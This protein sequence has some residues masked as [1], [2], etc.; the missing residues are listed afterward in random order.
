MP[1]QARH[2]FLTGQPGV[3]KTTL[4]CAAVKEQPA[5]CGFYTAEKRAAAGEREGF[6]V[7]AL[8]SGETGTLASLGRGKA[9][10]GKYCVDVASFERV[11]LPSLEASASSPIT[12]IDE[13]GKMEL[14]SPL[15]LPR[16]E[17]I[18]TSGEATV[19][20]TLPMPRYGHTIA[21]VE[22][23][24]AHPDVAVV[25]LTKANREAA[26]LA[27]RAVVAAAAARPRPGAPLDVSALVDFLQDGQEEKLL[28]AQGAGPGAP[29]E[30]AAQQPV[31]AVAAMAPA[32]VGAVAAVA[33]AAPPLLGERPRVLLLGETASAAPAPGE[34]PYAE[35]S[36]W[37]VRGLSAA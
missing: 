4:A 12:L 17:A 5:S 8:G 22:A 2:I 20:G 10:V 1:L 6:S 34:L 29:L 24:R 13:V 27:V 36:M 35:R 18:L 23:L 25:K 19:L 11:A 7:V 3:G 15:F 16:V 37:A 32:A 14:F 21:S 9:M 30:A 26:A 33:P 31:A 28:Q